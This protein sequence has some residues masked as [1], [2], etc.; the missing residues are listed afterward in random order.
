MEEKQYKYDAFISY[1]HCE[2]DKFVAENL[3]KIL[4]SYDLPKSVK[5]KLGITTK[6]FKRVFRDEEELPLSSNLED[7]IVDALENSKYLIVICSPRLKDSLWCKKEIQTFKKLRG[8]KNI[9]CVLIEGEPSDSF[10]EEVLYDEE[11]VTTKD[12]KT[13]TERIMVEPLAADVRGANNKEVLKKIKT[14]KLRL[15][16]PM[17][18]LDYDDLKQRQ[19][20]REQKRIIHI[21]T[22]VAVFSIAFAIYSLVMF[23]T[24]QTQQNILATHQAIALAEQ[25]TEYLKKDNRYDAVLKA[26][27][28]LT[29]FEYVTMPY[30]TDG[31]YALS[32]ALGVYDVGVS[33]KAITVLKT[34][35]IVDY[36]KVSP[37]DK[38]MAIY[39]E[40]ETITLFESNTLR[41]INK[42]TVRGSYANEYA[43][44]FLG[45]KFAYINYDG[46]IKIVNSNDGNE[47]KSIDSDKT[48]ISLRCNPNGKYI[49]YMT[50]N[51]LYIYNVEE[52]REVTNIYNKDGYLKNYYYS[53]NGD[54]LF[55]ASVPTNFDINKE[56]TLTMHVIKVSEGKEINSFTL[57][58]GYLE[59]VLTKGDNAYV[60]LNS[61]LGA[62]YHSIALSYNYIEGKMNWKNNYDNSWGKYIIKSF[63]EGT[64]DI[65]VTNNRN[66]VVLNAKDGKEVESFATDSDII[67]IYSFVNNNTYLVF[68]AN[69]E[70]NYINMDTKKAVE[71]KGKYEFNVE[72][73][74]SAVHSENG[75][76]LI[77][78]NENRII[79]YEEKKNSKAQEENITLDYPST[80][81]ISVLDVDKLK[82]EYGVKNRNLVDRMM[83]DTNKELLFVNY[84]N[85][86]IAIYNVNDKKLIKTLTNVGKINHYFGKDKYGRTYIGDVSDSYI[87]DK[88]YNKVGHIKNLAK[89][90]D[91]RVIV[92][93][94]KK[95]YSIK[96]YTLDDLKKEA[97]DY[98]GP[99]Y[100]DP[101]DEE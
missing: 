86:D 54:Y 91:D 9:F 92:R 17:F 55:V 38:Y 12:G 85:N 24:I 77:P 23:I 19:K 51:N 56:D 100:G 59:G 36:I 84:K 15:I 35:G 18:G 1:R 52:D 27:N 53:E 93:N 8:R 40:S 68:L 21:V 74:I 48:I 37:D 71:Y 89:L 32:E 34:D 69:G 11:K 95:Y 3:H 83:Y 94:D 43:F 72:S 28:S 97:E 14:E 99:N 16:A 63:K 49:S 67:N 58:A 70:V 78:E 62:K 82:D 75:F 88:D 47:V 7:P 90:E 42:Y 57:T 13:K 96:I 81:T 60:L 44:G 29:D 25:S 22:A 61:S 31:E 46:D 50:S 73:Y 6:A 66:V 65:A 98:L 10:P 4:E 64:N 80:D 87:L 5:K 30:T 33:F 45:D 2:L 76:I 79:L 26:Y 20:I 39:D 101:D 41:V